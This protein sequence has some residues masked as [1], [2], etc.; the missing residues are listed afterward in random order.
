MAP[1]INIEVSKGKQ[2]IVIYLN[3]LEVEG[4]EVEGRR[5]NTACVAKVDEPLHLQQLHG[6]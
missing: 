5:K 6:T 2:V 1:D 4:L 3:P